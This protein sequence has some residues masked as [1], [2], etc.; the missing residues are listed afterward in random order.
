MMTAHPGVAMV[1][2]A[3]QDL[4]TGPVQAMAHGRVAARLLAMLVLLGILRR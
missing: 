3:V 2:P 1:D 4:V